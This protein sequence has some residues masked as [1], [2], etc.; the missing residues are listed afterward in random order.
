MLLKKIQWGMLQ[1]TT[2]FVNQIRMLQ[3]TRMNIIGR[4]CTRGRTC[5]AFP[6]WLERLSSSLLS[7]VR[8]GYQFISVICLFAPLAVNFFFSFFC[9][10]ILAMGRQNRV[11]NLMNLDIKK[12]IIS[13]RESERSVGD[14]C[15]EY[16]YTCI[17]DFVSYFSCLNGCVGW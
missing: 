17:F 10:I 14:L 2:V 7:F 16:F 15:A 9:Y 12:E 13:K 11:R 8:F 4:R 5:C 6:L 1:Q 3:R